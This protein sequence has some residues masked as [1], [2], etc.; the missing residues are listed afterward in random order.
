MRD[1]EK[2]EKRRCGRKARRVVKHVLLA[3]RGY[4]A[5]ISSLKARI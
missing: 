4:I 2:R 1:G 5:T 3:W